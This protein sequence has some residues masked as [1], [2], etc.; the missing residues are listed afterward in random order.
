[1]TCDF[2]STAAEPGQQEKQPCTDATRVGARPGM[3]DELAARIKGAVPIVSG[4]SGIHGLLRFPAPDD[5][6]TAMSIFNTVAEAEESNRRALAWIKRMA[7]LV[8]G[9]RFAARASD[10]AF[11]ALS[12]VKRR[13][14]WVSIMSSLDKVLTVEEMK[15]CARPRS[16]AIAWLATATRQSSSIYGKRPI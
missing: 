11:A 5:T 8:M 12:C 4:V 2:K 1:M 3:A 15:E 16:G 14:G 7:S 6:V 9:R 10:S 13:V